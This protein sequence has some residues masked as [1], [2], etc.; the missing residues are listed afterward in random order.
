[1]P[2]RRAT[3][4][5]KAQALERFV[6]AASTKHDGKYDYSSIPSYKG[7]KTPV[8]IGCP[9]HGIFRQR[10]ANHL[11]GQGCPKCGHDNIRKSLLTPESELME[12][13]TKV[14]SGRYSYEPI[15]DYK[16]LDSILMI[17]CPVHGRFTQL[18]K[19][20]VVGAGCQKC[21]LNHRGV[22]SSKYFE[23][24]PEMVNTPAWVYMMRVG[25]FLKFGVSKDLNSRKRSIRS[26]SGL[27]VEVVDS[28]KMNMLQ[29][30]QVE[31]ALKRIFSDEGVMVLANGH[32]FSGRT[33][34]VS[35]TALELFS[36]FM[37]LINT[38][39][40]EKST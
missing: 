35:E 11:H 7:S 21:A 37:G 25:D 9:S 13:C 6:D 40:G 27:Q 16:G 32:T 8:P 39:M 17:S 1:M 15:D 29:A 24:H 30:Y 14:H 33:E 20:H 22:F 36:E 2:R 18:A 5:Q 12:R 23:E 3:E 28:F 19:R 38:N 4:E 34:C 31:R 26:E 10:P